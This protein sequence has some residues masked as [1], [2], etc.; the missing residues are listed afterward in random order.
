MGKRYDLIVFDWD[1]TVMDSTAVIA[2]SIQAACRDLDLPVPS[3]EDARHV[4]G[5]G[6]GQA[7]RHAVPT[8]P[9]SMYEPLAERY[10]HHFLAQDQ[11]IPLFEGARETIEELHGAGYW[12]GVATGKSRA[13][14]E[15]VLDASGLRSYFHATR[16]AD[17][18]FSKP[19]PAMLLELMDE[20]AVDADRTLMIGD[21]TH[22]VQLAQ[23]AGVDVVAVAYGAHP[24]EQLQE[25]APLALV[26]DFAEL[27]EW[28]RNNA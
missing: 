2:G 28:L 13:G 19:H 16:T 24:P 10:R 1:G 4:I 27:R 5:L 22:D 14:L 6:L 8:A 11:T 20:L 23:N 21:T 17:Q 26:G 3:D 15:R 9:E 25:L 18:T 12:L 7:L